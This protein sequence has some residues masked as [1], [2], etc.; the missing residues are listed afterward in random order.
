MNKPVIAGAAVIVACGLGLWYYL[1][2]G[3]KSGTNT[4]GS[5][6]TSSSAATSPPAEPAVAHP[7]PAVPGTVA[8]AG[9]AAPD[10]E[11]SDAELQAALPAAIGAAAVKDYLEPEDMIRRIVVTVD[12][13][14]RQKIPVD[15]RPVRKVGGL[16]HA[17][18]D[19]LHA[20]LDERNYARYQ[21]YVA[22]IRNLD[23]TA[24]MRIYVRV[25]PLLQHAY[26]D[27][28]YPK[29]YFNDRLVEATDVLL[30]APQVTGPI[31]LVRPN[32]MYEFAD[33]ALEARPAGQKLMIRMGP[34]NAA[35]VKA[36]LTELRAALTAAPPH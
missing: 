29:G 3:G 7:L 13:I 5:A 16:F 12:N 22:V 14:P 4:T 1:E 31:D 27:L 28:G 36:K 18:G 20:T 10:I 8:G 6:D 15:H 19:E 30:A 9:A 25:Y 35:A 24:L 26:Q 21:P 2:S 23:V 17:E 11:H 32:V 34:D 33:P